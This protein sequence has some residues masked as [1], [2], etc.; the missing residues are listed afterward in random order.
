MYFGYKSTQLL[1]TSLGIILFMTGPI[2]SIIIS[3]LIYKEQTSLKEKLCIFGSFVGVVILSLSASK[4][5][6]KA[7]PNKILG[8]ICALTAGISVG[9]T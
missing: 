3:S 4:S 9:A 5:T 7:F 2:F 6:H 8:V 1:P